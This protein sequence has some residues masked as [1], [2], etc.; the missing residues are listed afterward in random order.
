LNISSIT[1]T[2]ADPGDFSQMNNCGTGIGGHGSCTI[3]VTFRPTVR[4]T[5]SADVSI[6]DD[7][8]G[9]PQQV[10]LSGVGCTY[11]QW[12]KCTG[13]DEGLGRF[14][15]RYALAANQITSVPDP[16]GISRVGTRVMRLVDDTRDDP[17]VD[18][19]SKRELLVRFWYPASP[20]GDC[21]PA[22]YT[23]SKVWSYFSELVGL[24]G[25]IVKTNSCL[26]ARVVDGA[27]PVVVFTP[28]YTGTFTDY[29]F[30]VEDLAS[31]GY[32]VASVDHT[33]EATAAEFPDGRLVKGV[34]GSH[35]GH[36]WQIDDET[37][38]LALSVRSADLKFVLDELER[39]NA[40]ADSPFAGSLD[41]SR[42]GLMG[43]SLGGLATISGV[44]Q[45]PRFGSAVLLDAELGDEAF[46]G[47]DKAVLILAAGRERWSE[48]ECALWSNLRGPR[49]AVNLTGAEHV[50]LTDAVW[51]AKGA[52]KT[53]P[54][55]P[56][57][58][59]EAL[60]NYIDAFLD[61]NLRGKPFDPLLTGPASRYP[62]AAVTTQ[63]QSLC[64]ENID[65]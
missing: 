61:A 39:L 38:R 54:M 34:L 45:D 46:A 44:Q 19:H 64:G 60:R 20:D 58:T 30:I 5:R 13:S 22:E 12:H 37:L 24:P 32:I 17:Y 47:T 18:N 26:D 27:H 63:M 62:D 1:L 43:H 16:T 33:Y 29:T 48:S 35:L 49:I 7:G 65:H 40:A 6:S 21:K 14:A 3:T 4:G 9:S 53:G 50:T 57:K 28:G 8:G 15:A 41:T 59:I 51:L 52:I 25:P 31:R 42:I 56:E 55:G 2:G 23:S 10:S 11:N 36:T